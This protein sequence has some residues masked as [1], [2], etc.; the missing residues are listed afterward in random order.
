[1]DKSHEKSNSLN[2]HKINKYY[3][4]STL[5]MFLGQVGYFY[6][7][8][9]SNKKK[10]VDLLLSMPFFFFDR[11]LQSLLY[12]VIN[13]YA[14]KSYIDSNASMRIL[15]HTIYKDVSEQLEID[16][17]NH[18]VFYQNMQMKLHSDVY[19][20]KEYRRRQLNDVLFVCLFCLLIVIIYLYIWSTPESIV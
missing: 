19:E 18:D 10:C 5:K 8:S 15:C 17:E 12:D 14:I 6:A 13:K 9:K 16:Y 7:P 2:V 11:H 20:I 4:Q 1:M 3:V